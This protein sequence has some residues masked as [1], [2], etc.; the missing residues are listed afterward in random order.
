M[1]DP[2][3][4]GA[5]LGETCHFVDL[6]GWLLDSEPLSVSAYSLPTGKQDPIDRRRMSFRLCIA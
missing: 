6:L 3:I 1:A 2:A 5:I 4:G